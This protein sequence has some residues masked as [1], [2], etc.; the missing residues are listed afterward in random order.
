[1]QG[2]ILQKTLASL[3]AE[4]FRR[5]HFF[6]KRMAPPPPLIL[7]GVVHLKSGRRLERF[8]GY[9]KK[10]RPLWYRVFPAVRALDD[11]KQWG[12]VSL[13]AREALLPVYE[14]ET[15]PR[16]VAEYEALLQREFQERPEHFYPTG[17]EK[18]GFLMREPEE[19]LRQRLL[20]PNDILTTILDY[21]RKNGFLLKANQILDIG[22]GSGELAYRMAA[23]GAKGAI[24]LDTVLDFPKAYFNDRR[25][26]LGLEEGR[27]RFIRGSAYRLGFRDGSF[28]LVVSTA[29]LEH[30]D[31]LEE[32]FREIHRVLRPGGLSIHFYD[33]YFSPRGGHGL[34]VLDFPWGHVR[35]TRE[36]LLEYVA[37]VRPHEVCRAQTFLQRDIPPSPRSLREVKEA[38]LGAGFEIRA[39]DEGVRESHSSWI[40]GEILEQACKNFPGLP[41]R[42]LIVDTVWM[43]LAK[44]PET[45]P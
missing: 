30:L 7:Q 38:A 5:G 10:I 4:L 44:L 21:A 6:R 2:H 16:P 23:K 19:F 29:V 31:N 8:Q 34:L 45:R 3:K 36:E 1:M 40:G 18:T 13:P 22:C 42:D 41:A 37:L 14:S 12:L 28:D 27:C 20:A 26:A 24:G 9:R 11:L 43:V 39:W 17:R 35:L 15:L 25:E 32:A 33:P